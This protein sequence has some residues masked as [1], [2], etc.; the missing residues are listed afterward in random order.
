MEKS[1]ILLLVF[2]FILLGISY[3][4]GYKA[5]AGRF[6]WIARVSFL[7]VAFLLLPALAVILFYQS[8]AK[9]RLLQT[10]FVPYPEI[11]ETVGISF[12]TGRNPTWIFKVKTDDGIGEFYLD[13]SNRPG[14]SF[15]ESGENVNIYQ[16]GNSKMMVGKNRG[17]TSSS[18]IYMLESDQ[19]A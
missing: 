2:A 7:S 14:W 16:K 3:Y 15:V 1:T 19:D 9:D 13:E 18:I 17:L 8:S 11:T 5:P 4:L 6:P 10:G 12:G